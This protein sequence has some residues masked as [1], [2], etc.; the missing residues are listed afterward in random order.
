MINISI[1][2]GCGH[3]GLPFGIALARNPVTKVTLVDINEKSVSLINSG[4][5]PF[6]DRG[7]DKALIECLANKKIKASTSR[8]SIKTA[9]Y[10][11]CVIGTPVDEH[12]NP[13]VKPILD[14]MDKILSEAKDESTIILRSTIYPGTMRILKDRLGDRK[15]NLAFCPERVIQGKALEEIHSLPQIIAGINDKSFDS[16]N[17]LFSL[18]TQDRLR[19][20][21][22]EAEL[23]KLF[24]NSWRY[25]SFAVANQFF[26]IAESRGLD[27]YKIY[28]AM[29]YNYP[30]L[31]AL[32]RA[33]F[34]AGPCLFKDTM[35][36][37]AI[38]NNEFF[39]GH[40]AMLINEGLPRFIVEQIKTYRDIS[41][42]T[43][44]VLGMAFK[45]ENDDTR[46]SLSYKLKKILLTECHE[47]LCTDPYVKDTTLLPLPEVL[48]KADIFIVATPHS[49]YKNLRKR[50][51]KPIIDINDLLED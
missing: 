37:S 42:L 41:N 38:A 6:I 14:E 25:I 16:A 24:A 20:E 36:L 35:Q 51:L 3:V 49:E 30:R 5:V 10:I 39:L 9:D 29:K 4:F 34:A 2:G 43:V 48:E 47:V 12:L 23:A 45:A 27:F 22:E 33:G 1:I 40:S 26:M 19:L 18:I 46:E 7:A 50:T 17:D 28:S 15:I 13:T 32:P 11:V 31:N 8:E 44:G 21:P